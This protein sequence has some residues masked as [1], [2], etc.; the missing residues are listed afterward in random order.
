MEQYYWYSSFAEPEPVGARGFLA[1]AG[2]DLKFDL[3]PEG[4]NILGR[5][6]LL[7]WQLKT[8]RFK[9]AHFSLKTVQIFCIIN[10]TGVLVECWPYLQ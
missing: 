3:E 5:L 10:S 2:A 6:W 1:G 9:D 4:A 7:F 8:K